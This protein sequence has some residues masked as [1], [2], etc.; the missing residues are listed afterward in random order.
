MLLCVGFPGLAV[1]GLQM[2]EEPELADIL[3]MTEVEGREQ[4]PFLVQV[5]T[6]VT[7]VPE[8]LSDNGMNFHPDTPPSKNSLTSLQGPLVG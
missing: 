1:M 3:H 4:L 5:V 2:L 7:G 6:D 8:H